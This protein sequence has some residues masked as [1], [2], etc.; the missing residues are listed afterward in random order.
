MNKDVLIAAFIAVAA[1]VVLGLTFGLTSG[2]KSGANEAC[3]SI[4][5][6]WFGGKCVKVT[7]E[8]VK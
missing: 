2:Y 8:E 4:G 7:R 3:Q 5:L 6:E 1:S